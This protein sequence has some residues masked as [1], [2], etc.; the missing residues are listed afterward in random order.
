MG[1][2]KA[3]VRSR[4]LRRMKSNSAC[5]IGLSIC[6]VFLILGLAGFVDKQLFHRSIVSSVLNDPYRADLPNKLAPPSLAH[7]MGTDA[8][9]RDNAARVLYAAQTSLVVGLSSIAFAAPVGIVLGVVAAYFGGIV[10][11]CLMRAMDVLLTM[12]AILLALALVGIIG[13]GLTNVVLAIAIVNVPI[14]ARIV[15]GNALKVKQLEFIESA[16]A[17]GERDLAVIFSELLPNCLTPVVI[18]ASFSIALSILWEA[19]ISFMGVGVAPPET[20]WGLMISEGKNYIREAPWL[21]VF[22]GLAI[23]VVTLG[24]NLVGDGLRDALDPKFVVV[25]QG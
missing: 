16:R 12:P 17:I 3:M 15:R 24:F 4:A 13:R 8:L 1:L 5:L 7:T 10:D 19:S 6:I 21:S 11:E 2:M 14:F 18:Q 25:Q 23:M 20:S 22:P 9:G